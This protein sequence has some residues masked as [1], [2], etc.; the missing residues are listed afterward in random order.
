AEMY[1]PAWS[2]DGSKIAFVRVG[3]QGDGHDHS[4]DAGADEDGDD[5]HLW[6]MKADGSDQRPLTNGARH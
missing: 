2:P 6:L 5:G 1:H 4:H 3:D